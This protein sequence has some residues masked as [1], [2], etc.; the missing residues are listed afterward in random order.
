L[1]GDALVAAGENDAAASHFEALLAR[2]PRSTFRDIAMNG[3]G[4]IALRAGDAARALT[5]ARDAVEKGGG[6]YRSREATLLQG[7]ALIALKRLDEAEPVL[8]RVAST[9]EWRG[10]ATAQS[11]FLLGEIADQ[12]GD[13]PKAIAFYQR[14]FLSHQRYAEWVARSYLASAADF[15]KL[16]RNEEAV[17]TLR[18]ML[19]NARIADRPEI[20]EAR[21][22]LAELEK[23]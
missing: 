11:L 23:P 21:T 14:V 3:L 16:G 5:W 15:K 22:R 7:R 12:R 4:E 10:E 17:N 9:K 13:L 20:A 19:R 2:Y 8:T 6:L 18:E 1:S